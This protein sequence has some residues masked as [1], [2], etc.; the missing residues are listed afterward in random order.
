M[1]NLEDYN[2]LFKKSDEQCVVQEIENIV[3]KSLN[4]NRKKNNHDGIYI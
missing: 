2:K 4:N 3:T 1:R